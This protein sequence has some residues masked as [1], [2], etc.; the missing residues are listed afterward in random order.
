[1][2]VSGS[3]IQKVLKDDKIAT[4]TPEDRKEMDERD[5]GQMRALLRVQEVLY[6]HGY[7]PLFGTL[8]QAQWAPEKEQIQGGY[9]CVGQTEIQFVNLSQ[10]MRE[11]IE[12]EF[13]SGKATED[14]EG[15]L[16][17]GF[18]VKELGAQIVSK[19]IAGIKLYVTQEIR[20]TPLYMSCPSLNQGVLMFLHLPPP[21]TPMPQVQLLKKKE[22]R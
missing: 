18:N 17:H 4:L 12:T 21:P 13:F 9:V 5:F 3:K 7:R 1:M 14:R 16:H 11:K 6:L 19:S 15:V 2:L 10:Q 8:W 22:E 20:E